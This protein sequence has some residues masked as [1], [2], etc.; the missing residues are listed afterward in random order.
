M[1]NKI[2][3]SVLLLLLISSAAYCKDVV[4]EWDAPTTNVD[5][6]PVT[7]LAGFR[8]YEHKNSAYNKIGSDISLETLTTTI[9]LAQGVY[10]FIATAY[11]TSGNESDYS[12][13]V[14]KDMLSPGTFELRIKTN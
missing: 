14:C 10:C 3:V 7:D 2:I 12:N 1:L 4:L 5:G 6:T 9:N 11:D 13:E 8:I